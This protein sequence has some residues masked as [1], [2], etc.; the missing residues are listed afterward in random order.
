MVSL[1]FAKAFPAIAHSSDSKNA[2]VS[3]WQFQPF[4]RVT[5]RSLT[6]W[7]LAM[8]LFTMMATTVM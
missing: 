7:M 6:F 8:L 5:M 2:S 4:P 3:K 1:G